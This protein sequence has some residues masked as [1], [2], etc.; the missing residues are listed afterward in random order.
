MEFE[1]FI[2]LLVVVV[3]YL[4]ALYRTAWLLPGE[5]RRLGDARPI[6]DLF[7]PLTSYRWLPILFSEDTREFRPETRHAFAL[8]RIALALIPVAFLISVVLASNFA[9][10]E[11][12]NEARQ[13]SIRAS[14]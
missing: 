14:G 8:A 11:K 1:I 7:D 12:L 2:P 3:P 5:R 13:H 4:G 10:G 9:T 6:P